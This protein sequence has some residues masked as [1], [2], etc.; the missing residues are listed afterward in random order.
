MSD[1]DIHG[2]ANTR[3]GRALVEQ[4]K[5]ALPGGGDAVPNDGALY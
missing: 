5:R 4:A 3:A 2:S 1:S